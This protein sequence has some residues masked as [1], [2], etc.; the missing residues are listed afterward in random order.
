M[1]PNSVAKGIERHCIVYGCAN[2]SNKPECSKLSWHSLPINNLLR[3][4]LLK[5]KRKD[6]PVP[7]TLVLNDF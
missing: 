7:S 2:R 4:W 3:T 5:M 6:P 1:W